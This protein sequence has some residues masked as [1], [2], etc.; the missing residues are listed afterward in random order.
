MTF[1]K[2]GQAELYFMSRL[3]ILGVAHLPVAGVSSSE[4][5]SLR[6]HLGSVLVS[7]IH[8]QKAGSCCRFCESLTTEPAAFE[9]HR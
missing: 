2:G 9:M 3:A 7:S 1:P 6:I 4:W 8:H 5:G